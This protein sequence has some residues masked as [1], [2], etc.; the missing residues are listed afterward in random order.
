MP[1]RTAIDDSLN[2]VFVQHYDNYVV[3]EE[4]E[5]LSTLLQNPAYKKNMSLLRD[6]TRTSFPDSYN[7]DWFRRNASTT[8]ALTDDDLGT[9]RKVA[10]VLGSV[11]DYTVVHQWSA[12]GRLN[13][14][15]MERRP[16]RDIPKAL[17]WL[18]IPDGYVV[19]YPE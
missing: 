16:F 2:C 3:G 5:Q 17:K 9:N 8:M 10:W 18:G 6:V 7:L 4:M 13:T 19:T 11:K 12:V 15:V 1:Y 14:K